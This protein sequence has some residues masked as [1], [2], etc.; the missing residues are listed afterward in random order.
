MRIRHRTV[1]TAILRSPLICASRTLGQ[2]PFVLEQVLEEVI[3]P[4]RRSRGPDDFQAAAN[5]ISAFARTK[6]ALPAETLLLDAGGFRLRSN[7]CCVTRA[8]GFAERMSAGNQR[9]R[10]LVI[11]RHTSKRLADIPCC[12]EW[13]RIAIRSFGIHVNQAHLNRRQRI[14]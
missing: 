1:A 3:A 10:L 4:L 7:V 12:G 9:N 2:F 11:H 8:V 5:R 6:L 14:R 13:I